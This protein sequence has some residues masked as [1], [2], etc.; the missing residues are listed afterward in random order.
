LNTVG[1]EGDNKYSINLLD[2][3][4]NILSST[5]EFSGGGS[6]GNTTTT[7]KI[8]LTK[9]SLNKTIKKGDDVDISFFFDHIDTTSLASTGNPATVTTTIISGALSTTK[10]MVV[11]AGTNNTVDVMDS[12]Q[13]GTNTVRVKVEVDNGDS[14]Q[15]S[16][17][18]WSVQVVNLVLTS[19]YDFATA[20]TRGTTIY[21]PFT[22]QGA[23]GKVLSCYVNGAKIED[24]TITTSSSTG[25]FTIPTGGYTHGNI[26]VQL[27]AELELIGGNIPSNSIYY[28]LV[29]AEGYNTAPV[30][31][32]KMIYPDGRLIAPNGRPVITARQFEDFVINYAVYDPQRVQKNVTVEVD[33][34]IISNTSVSFSQQKVTSKSV[35]TGEL[36]ATIKTGNVRYTFTVDVTSSSITLN[37]PADNLIF[38]FNALGKSNNDIGRNE[39]I[40][41]N[42]TIKA[43][44]DNV[45]YGGDGW[46]DNALR[47]SDNGTATINY[48]PLNASNRLINNSLTFQIK[49]KNTE[50]TNDNAEVIKCVDS[51]GTG[52]VITPTEAR[53]TTKGKADVS[54]K[55]AS[56]EVY[57]VAFVSYPTVGEDSSEHEKLNN[58]MVYLYINGIMSGAVQRANSD[59]IYQNVPT[60]VIIGGNGATTDIY[61][62]RCY[63]RYLNDSEVLDL[64]I[65]DIDDVN[66]LI[67]TYNFNNQ[68]DGNGE[69]TVDNVPNDMRYVIITGQQANGQSTVQYAQ[70]QNNKDTRYDVTEILHIKKSEPSLN[71][72]C[73]GGCIRLQGTSSLAYPIKNFRFYFKNSAKVAGQLLLG[74]D[75][76]GN[77]G[78]LSATPKFSFKL[79]NEKGKIPAPVDV[80]CLKA[81]FAE[82]SS[83]HN[84]GMAKLTN[85]IL[86]K[87]GSLTPAQKY[88][89]SSHPYDV[90]TTV[91]GEPCYL[92]GRNSVNDTPKFIGKFNLNNDKSTE[93]VF[94]FLNIPGYHNA[95]WVQT[96]FNG[97]NPTECW[98]FLNNDY[99][100]GSYLDD[101]FDAKVDV[102]G[103]LTPNWMR[104]F[105]AR[106][107]DNNDS[108]ED[109]VKKPENLQRFV[110]WVKSTETNGAKFKAEL[111][112]YA[113]VN[114]LCDYYM[115]TDIF[116]AVDQR[117]K[118]QMMGFWYSPDVDKMLAYF[119]FYDNDTIMGVRND[120][121]LKYH[122]DIDHDSIDTEITAST[123]N[124]K[125]AFE[126]HFSL[127]WKNLRENFSAELEASFKRL[128]SIMSNEYIL[129]MFGKEQTEKFAE[130]IYNIDAQNKYVLPKTKGVEVIVNGTPSTVSYSYLEAMQGNR[131]P[132][133]KWWLTNR[134]NLFDGKY[135]AGDYSNTAITW[136]GFSQI[137]ATIKATPSR[138]YYFQIKR[139]GTVMTHAKVANN[140]EWSYS[141]NQVANIGTIFTLLGGIFMKS[142][143]MSEWGGFTDLNLPKLPVLQ[144]LTLGGGAGKT[145][146]L[147]E[148]DLGAKL[149]MVTTIDVRNFINIPSLDVSG[150][151]RLTTLNARGCTA[152]SSI[153]LAVGSPI[154]SLTLPQNLKTLKLN[155]FSNLT[156]D[157]I[158]FPDGKNVETLVVD[159]CPLINW[160]TLYNSLSAT[161]KNIR[162]TGINKTGSVDWLLRFTALGGVDENGTITTTCA[163]VGNYQLINFISDEQYNSLSAHYPELV[164]NQPKQTVIKYATNIA[165]PKNITNIDN[166]TGYGTGTDYIPNGHITQI[167]NQRYRC[168]GK[169]TSLGK[170]L[171]T[172]LDNNDSRLFKNKLD[173]TPYVNG[174]HGDVYVYE[175]HYWLKGVNDFKNNSNYAC[176]SSNDLPPKAYEGR[177]ITLNKD[178]FTTVA[179]RENSPIQVSYRESTNLLNV[180][181]NTLLSNYLNNASG[182]FVYGCNVEGFKQIRFP[183]ITSDTIFSA[184]TT[185]GAELNSTVI[186]STKINGLNVN[187]S[188]GMYYVFNIPA[189][190]KW[191]FMTFTTADNFDKVILTDST[192]ILDIE[193][194]WIE[195]QATL[196]SAF[197]V[198]Y[199]TGGGDNILKSFV[200]N[201]AVVNNLTFET[202]ENYIG[203]LG[204]K[205][206]MADYDELKNITN[207]YYAKYGNRNSQV[208]TGYGQNSF[209][210]STTGSTIRYGMNDS[211]LNVNDNG[212][213]YC[214]FKVK[215]SDGTIS[216]IQNNEIS[217]L[218]YEDLYGGVNEWIGGLTTIG[219]YYVNIKGGD[220]TIR[221][222][223]GYNSSSTTYVQAV[224]FGLNMDIIP[225]G[226]TSAGTD[227]TYYCDIVGIS[228]SVGNVPHRGGQSG[229]TR[230]DGGLSSLTLSYSPTNNVSTVTARIMFRGVIEKT[231][232]VIIFINS[233]EIA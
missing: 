91:D 232:N 72:K 66:T 49:F 202:Y 22:L 217:A 181:A 136:K 205:L 153:A 206:Q 58:N 201:K 160:E 20:I 149:P 76:Q 93:D 2:E 65:I 24:R 7:T 222:V 80:W 113:D 154:S 95:E 108:Y 226:A 17:I 207:L 150:C 61:N 185:T 134:L 146:S 75:T 167:L 231:E 26:S 67:N 214:L 158:L 84:T 143:N 70:V 106:F 170:M 40:S 90:R 57:N 34:V 9:L 175:P 223:K 110:K 216:T 225:C 189:N 166:N 62:I 112:D 176:Y 177:T 121:R 228:S 25:S 43:N 99:P 169:Q 68:V 97:V 96:K 37:E 159:N 172:P 213:S 44:L 118:N 203:A 144:S 64:Q 127:L 63:N 197:D 155:S 191:V 48:Q 5:D 102:D 55:L 195:H 119:I 50:I 6:G 3:N 209:S 39:W 171:I 174:T 109:G 138:D 233:N 107:P 124:T 131:T 92:F 59:V 120:G 188:N 23:G 194:N 89:S 86:V 151:Q 13:L 229:Q 204:R 133:R 30:V 8:I 100:M 123:G 156:N 69:V 186:G 117:V 125:Y 141:Y 208:Q 196:V 152:L 98:E 212:Y 36:L 215:N 11:N 77:G 224:H 147:T 28:D 27:V 73:N 164:I 139:E 46:L 220:G 94:G 192:D 218:G 4:G 12:L 161:V 183:A 88:V 42:P 52:F 85:D 78:T 182:Y 221:Q 162:V 199:Y 19:N 45:K 21:L 210:R 10:V 15:V 81:D 82:S 56:G 163:L 173:A 51:E 60:N 79:P 198:S 168:L 103:T 111:K 14:I 187:F 122:W 1:E 190:A 116:G 105:E 180:T 193:P 16:T 227:S 54:M 165:D 230:T 38:K 179:G 135:S 101:D 137:G 41:N 29:I 114:S 142:L 178:T 130:R 148:L 145:Y 53:L 33:N 32:T 129:S 18:T 211:Q 104:V 128:R 157:N 184:I 31:A 219:G 126:G 83:S 35:K 74:V 140:V 115:F 200:S 132:H 47:L 71:F 87:A